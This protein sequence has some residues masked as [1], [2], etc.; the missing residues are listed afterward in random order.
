MENTDSEITVVQREG[1]TLPWQNRLHLFSNLWNNRSHLWWFGEEMKHLV[2][3][4][5]R[6][7]N[8]EQMEFTVQRGEYPQSIPR[9]F[10][11][12]IFQEEEWR[13]LS[14]WLLLS[15]ATIFHL[16][17]Q[18]CR[19]NIKLNWALAFAISSSFYSEC[20]CKRSKL[21]LNLA[22]FKYFISF[23]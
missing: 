19:N 16:P 13:K 15:E 23:L 20:N 9:N 3:V 4:W 21:Q 11:T 14:L 18:F 7:V 6:C 10:I 22:P 1:D 2:Q 8:Q 5:N 12:D 17:H